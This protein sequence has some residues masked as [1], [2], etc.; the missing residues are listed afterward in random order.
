MNVVKDSSYYQN[1]KLVITRPHD[2]ACAFADQVKASNQHIDILFQPILGIEHLPFDLRSVPEETALITTSKQ[3]SKQVASSAHSHFCIS[4]K[5]GI[6]DVA[7]LISHIKNNCDKSQAFLY[8]RGQ[9]ISYDL[10]KD[11]RGADYS[12][13]EEI[14]YNAH[15]IT[16][17][18]D[19]FIQAL[20]NGQIG[21]ISFFSARTAQIFE[22]LAVNHGLQS[23][24]KS[25]NALCL[26]AQLVNSLT[27]LP[28]QQCL[29][30]ENKTMSAMTRLV[31]TL[32]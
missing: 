28:W 9:D 17:F 14:V 13:A 26:S 16:S 7:D 23:H 1:H 31:K 21:H 5:D 32:Y 6:T 29:V 27:E 12:V 15:P 19:D 2:G 25:I 10:S 4:D 30:C 22:E 24:F 18:N 3:A 11:L 8:L 20:K